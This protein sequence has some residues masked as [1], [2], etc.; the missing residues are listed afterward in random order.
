MAASLDIKM[1]TFYIRIATFLLVCNEFTVILS[2][3]INGQSQNEMLHKDASD[4]LD[5]VEYG[6]AAIVVF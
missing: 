4:E 5:R 2:F 6:K 3:P 1:A